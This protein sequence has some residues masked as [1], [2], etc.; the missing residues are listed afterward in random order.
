MSPNRISS[1]LHDSTRQRVISESRLNE[2]SPVSV[3]ALKKVLLHLKEERINH[4]ILDLRGNPGGNLDTLLDICNNLINNKK[5]FYSKDR[6]GNIREY[7]S[8]G[9]AIPFQQRAVLIDEQTKSAAELLAL[10]LREDGALI[11][12]QKSFGKGVSQRTF[13]IGKMEFRLTTYEYFSYK[14]GSFHG[15]GILPDCAFESLHSLYYNRIEYSGL[16][17]DCEGL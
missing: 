1:L 12:G 10:V 9:E 11:A 15:C 6:Q 5:L 8:E 7:A 13:F 2:E 14:T 17:A 16:Q 4:L 3:D